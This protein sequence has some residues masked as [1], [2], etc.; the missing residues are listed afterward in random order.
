MTPT[1]RTLRELRTST[2]AI[3][4][5][6]MA[7]ILEVLSSEYSYDLTPQELHLRISAG[8]QPAMPRMDGN[9]AVLPIRGFLM[10]KDNLVTKILGGTSTES[11][12]ASLRQ[13]AVDRSVSAIVLDVDS[14]GGSV[15][16]IS[17]LAADIR[18]VRMKKPVVAVANSLAASA[19]YWLSSQA[20]EL[21]VAPGGLVGSIGVVEYHSD[22]SKAEEMDGVKTTIISAGKYKAETNPFGPLSDE[23]QADIQA[24]VDSYY[25]DF[26]RDVAAGRGATVNQVRD[27]YG[28]G[29]IVTANRAVQM[30]MADKVA[31]LD[32]VLAKFTVQPASRS[33]RALEQP[34]EIAAEEPAAPEKPVTP[35]ELR[36]RQLELVGL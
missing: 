23:A 12:S 14:P 34:A 25:Q 16:G 32:Q 21:N 29:R 19:A 9:V 30:G 22:I 26:L 4:P 33:A 31:T 6:K 2:L 36:R 15:F 24:R 13:Y 28:Q 5:E 8:Y 1:I 3:M 7:T 35:L 27:G 20:S 11:I 17:A 10:Q 18:A